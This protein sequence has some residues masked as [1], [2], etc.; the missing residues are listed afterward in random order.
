M[1]RQLRLSA[2]RDTDLWMREK[3]KQWRKQGRLRKDGTLKVDINMPHARPDLTPAEVRAIIFA[4]PTRK[5]RDQKQDLQRMRGRR[6]KSWR[7]RF[8]KSNP[9][10]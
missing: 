2:Q 7:R 9:S 10:E 5:A 6:T 8:D 4:L 3:I 1:P